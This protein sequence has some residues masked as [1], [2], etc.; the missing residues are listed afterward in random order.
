MTP[1]DSSKTPKKTLKP[2]VSKP[3]EMSGD[4]IEFIN[5]IDEFKRRNMVAHLTLER[6]IDVVHE[7]GYVCPLGKADA[8]E[9]AYISDAVD[10][11]KRSHQRLFPNWSEVFE[12]LREIGYE[13]DGDE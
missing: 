6:V 10:E 9:I 8:D 12:V 1:P 5:A 3:D 7:L 2:R 4:L 11:Y 13:R